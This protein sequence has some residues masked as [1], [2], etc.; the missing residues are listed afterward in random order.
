MEFLHICLRIARSLG[1]APWVLPATAWLWLSCAAGVQA[2]PVALTLSPGQDRLSIADKVE[3]LEDPSRQLRVDQVLATARAWRPATT[4]VLNLAHSPSAWWLHLRLIG[5][6]DGEVT[7]VLELDNP[8]LDDIQVH[9]LHPGGAAAH[10]RTGD[11]RPFTDRP[12]AYH[13]FAFPLTVPAGEAVDVL[14]RLDSRDGFL[15]LLPIKLWSEQAFQQG[16]QA[17]TLLCGLYYGALL[18]LLLYHLC[19]LGSTRQAAFAWYVS[20]LFCLVATRFA[21]EGHAAQ[22]LQGLPLLW[23]NQGLLINYS[24]SVVLFGAMLIANVK[25]ALAQR[26]WLLRLCWTM[27]GLNALPV[28]LALAGSYSGTL[29]LAMPATMASIVFAMGL[30]I[31]AWRQGLRHTRFFLLGAACMLV[32]L[33]AERMRLEAT[34]PD[35]PLL[36]YGVA[37]GSVLEALCIA[38]ALAESMNQMKADKLLAER[39]AR[40]AEARL[41]NELGQLVQARTRELEAANQRLTTLSITDELTGAF[42]RRHF[43][44]QLA[45][46]LAHARREGGAIGLCL[47]DLDHFKGYNDHYGHPAGDEVLRRVSATVQAGLKR[48]T[49]RLFR[50]GGEEFALLLS[51]PDRP[52]LLSFLNEVRHSIEALGIP[53]AQH[54]AGVVTASFGLAW[55]DHAATAETDEE[56]LYRCADELLYRA[57]ARGRNRIDSAEVPSAFAEHL[58]G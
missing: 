58:A 20:Y 8:R 22:Y 13:G 35:H 57:K 49:D 9:V 19:L 33:M 12:I 2:A 31:W 52:Q 41:N 17:H 27:V 50:V 42:N 4:P 10:Y 53:H 23:I 37:I 54:R 45:Y 56:A 43:Q 30:S 5:A 18:I 25:P 14:V 1:L 40:E 44:D 7:R 47:F 55:C 34:L 16:M 24:L 6:A 39:Q 36:A 21:F 3:L 38:I 29:K 11:Q 32:G 26:P 15:G 48:S 46:R 28:P 51:G